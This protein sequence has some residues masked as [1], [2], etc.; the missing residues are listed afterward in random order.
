MI[1]LKI[2]QSYFSWQMQ[3]LVN[4]VTI[5]IILYIINYI[6]FRRKYKECE[7]F[8]MTGPKFEEVLSVVAGVALGNVSVKVKSC[9]LFAK[10]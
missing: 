3:Y 2:L 10:G 4:L 6:F 8:C 9:F 1:F 7:S 5:I